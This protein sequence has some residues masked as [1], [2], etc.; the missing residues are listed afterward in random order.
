LT[1]RKVTDKSSKIVMSTLRTI[2]VAFVALS[3]AMLPVAGAQA[4]GLPGHASQMSSQTDCCSHGQ[5]YA[6]RAMADRAKDQGQGHC[7]DHCGGKCLCLGL[8]AVLSASM[9]AL[10]APISLLKTTRVA[11]SARAPAYVPPAPPP[12][13]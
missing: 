12:R 6:A 11:E 9:G 13:V 1:A 5:P 2:I 8:T 4:R 7:A 3:L 10:A